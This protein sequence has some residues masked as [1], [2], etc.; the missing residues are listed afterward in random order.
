MST[1]QGPSLLSVSRESWWAVPD[2]E[3]LA[4]LGSKSAGLT[5]SGASSRLES[6]GP[7]LVHPRQEVTTWGLVVRQFRSPL[8]LIL[9]LAAIVS[10]VVAEWLDATIILSIV[11]GSAALGFF[12]EHRATDAVAQLRTRIQLRTAVHRDGEVQT[13][14]AADL[15]PGDVVVLGTGAL[16]PADGRVLSAVDCHATEAILT[17]ETFPVEKY[18]GIVGAET[19]IDGRFGKASMGHGL[20]NMRERARSLG[21]DM[22]LT[23]ST[24]GGLELEWRV[25]L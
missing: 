23:N 16:V 4:R 22:S 21:G 8:V 1:R 12:Q 5:R 17:G 24:Q 18:A 6:V 20:A 13:I 15:V 9:V 7:N 10:G 25:P 2:D 14:P 19:P 3:L 11:V